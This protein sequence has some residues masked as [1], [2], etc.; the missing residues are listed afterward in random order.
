MGVM[1]Q[2]YHL[3]FITCLS[4]FFLELFK[5]TPATGWHKRGRALRLENFSL[6]T[7]TKENI[8]QWLCQVLSINGGVQIW[9]T[10]DRQGFPHTYQR[11]TP[12][13]PQQ[14][15]TWESRVL[16]FKLKCYLEA[17]SL[18]SF[19]RRIGAGKLT[20]RS[21]TVLMAFSFLFIKSS[22]CKTKHRD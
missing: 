14:K 4:C 6:K 16:W 12:G 3:Q 17:V 2:I 18:C 8:G 13:Q 10:G 5:V 21:T 7:G 15:E 9:G 19:S 11:S 1:A 20:E 22:S